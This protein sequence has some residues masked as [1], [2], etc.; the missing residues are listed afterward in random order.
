MACMSDVDGH[1]KTEKVCALQRP[2]ICINAFEHKPCRTNVALGG[3]L[4]SL[5]LSVQHDG[6]ISE[7]GSYQRAY[8]RKHFCWSELNLSVCSKAQC[9]HNFWTTL[10]K[11]CLTETLLD[12]ISTKVKDNATSN[13]IC[14]WA[15]LCEIEG[16][17]LHCK[18]CLRIMII[19]YRKALIFLCR[20][21]LLWYFVAEFNGIQTF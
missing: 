6:L 7:F 13:C 15:S 16:N 1:W 20:C 18:K 14:C 11:R 4:L 5:V 21:I 10:E 2:R 3:F 8:V 17:W 12:Q 9:A 19:V